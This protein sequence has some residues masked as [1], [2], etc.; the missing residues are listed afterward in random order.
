MAFLTSW[1]EKLIIIILIATLL[2][3]FLPNNRFQ[4]YIKVVMGLLI[5]L[6]MIQPLEDLLHVQ[7]PS[8]SQLSIVNNQNSSE[9]NQIKN[10]KSEI[11]RDDAAYIHKQ[12]VV[13][14][15]DRV[16]KEVQQTYGYAIVSIKMTTA[17]PTN[18]DP[19]NISHLT[20]FV[21]KTSTSKTH[22]SDI[23]VPSVDPVTIEE[24][25]PSSNHPLPR[26]TGKKLIQYL[27]A[28]WGIDAKKI[29]IRAVGG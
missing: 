8:S 24:S 27:A 13:Q 2:E 3:L 14:L 10:L 1:S 28:S 5:V 7:T 18:A 15:K 21:T 12:M 26:S 23:T 29:V 20:V 16:N 19:V 17:A 4:P 25:K 11:D 22:T 9:K 6:I